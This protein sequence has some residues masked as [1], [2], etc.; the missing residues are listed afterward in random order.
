MSV[1]DRLE[2]ISRHS[3]KRYERKFLTARLQHGQLE[4]LV[5]MHPASFRE[6]FH[7]RQINNIYFDTPDLRFFHDNVSGSSRRLKIRIRWYGKDQRQVEQPRLELKYKEGYVGY[8]SSWLLPAFDLP[9]YPDQDFFMRDVF[10]LAGL[11]EELLDQLKSVEPKLMNSYRR[12]YF[13][14]FDRSF[15]FTIDQ[16]LRFHDIR[17]GTH[18]PTMAEDLLN[19]Q[20][21]ELK[22]DCVWDDGAAVVIN[23]LPMRVTKS[24]KYV[25]G[26]YRIRPDLAV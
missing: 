11:P 14:S 9:D 15:R 1:S 17:M 25:S 24:S 7:L 26:M 23:A 4:H 20:V 8:K 22:Y 3:E 18:S 5:R 19:E 6:I 16:D 10:L 2:A 12:K 13:L 21:L